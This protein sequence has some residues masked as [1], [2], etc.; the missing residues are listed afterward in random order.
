MENSKNNKGVIVLLVVIIVILSALCI[1]L[2]TGTINFNLNKANNNLNQNINENNKV[3][4]T[5]KNFYDV[6]DLNVDALDE[7]QVFDNISNNKNVT[8]SVRVGDKYFADLDITGKVK[9]KSYVNDKWITGDLSVNNIMDII[10]FDVPA[11]ETEQLLYLL[12]DTGDVYWYKFGEADNKNFAVV[13]VDNISNVQKLFISHFAKENAGG[14]WAL[15]AIT[16]NSDCV[17][18]KGESV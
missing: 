17:M 5:T 14:S 7:Y 1:L 16:K 12:T 4:D 18:L 10:V 2:A 15:F 8:E 13:K 9:V 3:E 11:P 6:N